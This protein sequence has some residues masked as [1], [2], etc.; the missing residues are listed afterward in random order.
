MCSMSGM[1]RKSQQIAADMRRVRHWVPPLW[2]AEG[3]EWVALPLLLA[4]YAQWQQISKL[5]EPSA[6]ARGVTAY[7][8]RE[9]AVVS[10]NAGC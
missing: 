9:Y 8:G 4:K 10:S 2:I 3:K 1:L 7:G 6:D 5:K